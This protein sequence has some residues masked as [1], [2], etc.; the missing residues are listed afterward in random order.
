MLWNLF[1]A[2]AQLLSSARNFDA[3]VYAD[4]LNTFKSFAKEVDDQHILQ[5][6]NEMQSSL[7]SW[8]ENNFVY[9]DPTKESTHILSRYR[10][11]AEDFRILGCL[12]DCK[13]TMVDAFTRLLLLP[14]AKCALYYEHL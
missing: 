6:L 4:D 9:F 2:D 8:G 12:F 11:L 14:I 1:F 7:H 10:P 13:L 3:I 5:E